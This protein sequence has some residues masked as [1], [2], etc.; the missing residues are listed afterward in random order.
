MYVF[1]DLN[2][3]ELSTSEMIHTTLDDT[4]NDSG[5]VY[6]NQFLSA[7]HPHSY[8]CYAS[9]EQSYIPETQTS[10]AEEQPPQIYAPIPMYSHQS[11]V[12]SELPPI[13]AVQDSVSLPNT[14]YHQTASSLDPSS[15]SNTG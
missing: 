4:H 15:H 1:V 5:N 9:E 2:Q 11:L 3:D 8:P 14:S 12:S 7:A 6:S 10:V 13:P